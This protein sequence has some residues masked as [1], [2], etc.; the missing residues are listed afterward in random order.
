MTSDRPP[1]GATGDRPPG[2]ALRNRLPLLLSLAGLLL[3]AVL[4]TRGTS[5]VPRGHG[6]VIKGPEQRPVTS[7]AVV[8]V[9]HTSLDKAGAAS[10]STVIVI[11]LI[12]YLAGVVALIVMLAS[13]RLHR[14]RRPRR[15]PVLVDEAEEGLAGVTGIALL[16]GARAALAGLRQRTGGPPS[17]AVQRAWLVMEEA[18]AEGGTRRRPEQTP[19]EFTAA[20]LAEHEVDPAALATLRGLYQRARFG[21]ADAVT[22]TDAEAAIGALERIA[23]TLTVSTGAD[24]V[25]GT[26]ADPVVGGR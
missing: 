17:D 21:R 15:P 12:A 9:P 7:Q 14:A 10:L 8:L 16:Q 20:V 5:A 13:V 22:E 19:T 6:L 18:A 26:G 23:D 25:V 4:A 3:L 1:A 24:P 11:A 2:G